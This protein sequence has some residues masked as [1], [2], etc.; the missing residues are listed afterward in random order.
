MTSTDDLAPYPET[1]EE[2]T[3]D[4]LARHMAVEAHYS[5]TLNSP[6]FQQVMAAEKTG[7][8]LADKRSLYMLNQALML[9][10][11]G[12]AFLL[13]ELQRFAP[14]QADEVAARMWDMWEDPP[15][16]A[17]TW[18]A[19][20]SY[21]IDPEQV[22]AAAL[23]RW[24]AATNPPAPAPAE[25]EYEHDDGACTECGTTEGDIWPI[26]GRV[27]YFC[28]DCCIKITGADPAHPA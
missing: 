17:I 15:L 7:E 26:R 8:N 21:G 5:A 6:R 9:A 14:D 16:Q 18:D 10:E 27:G 1:P 23:A 24:E 19:L 20:E 2:A 11:H 3:A 13:H 22:S 12:V 25:I 4:N 28:R